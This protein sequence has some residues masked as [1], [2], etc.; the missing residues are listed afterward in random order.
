LRALLEEQD[1]DDK[2]RSVFP[3]LIVHDRSGSSND[4]NILVVEA[5]E[6]PADSRGVEYDRLK[7]AAYQHELL[8]QHAVYIELGTTPRWQWMG[9]DNHLQDVTHLHAGTPRTPR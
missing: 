7:L 6:S 9:I 1:A 2:K 4:H 5:K 3:D 8:Y